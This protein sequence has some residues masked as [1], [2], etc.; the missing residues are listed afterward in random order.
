MK[1]HSM[2]VT[3]SNLNVPG[4]VLKKNANGISILEKS[5]CACSVVSNSW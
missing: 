4:K 3:G 5:I 1:S 2:K